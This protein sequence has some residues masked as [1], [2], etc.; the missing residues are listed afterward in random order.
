MISSA[1]ATNGWVQSDHPPSVRHTATNPGNIKICGDHICKPFENSKKSL[2]V[3]NHPISDKTV[4][5]I[6]S[7]ISKSFTNTKK[8]QTI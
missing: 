4:N 7:Q 5:K 3:Q 8:E 2:L 1:S 6:V